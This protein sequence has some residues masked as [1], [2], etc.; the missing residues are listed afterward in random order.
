MQLYMDNGYMNMNNIINSS[1]PFIIVINGRGTGKTFNSLWY[2]LENHI[3]F[4]YMRRTKTQIEEIS[5]P[6]RDPFSDINKK[7]GTH[8]IPKNITK[9]TVGIY[10]GELQDDIYVPSGE[11]LGYICALSTFSTMRGLVD[12]DIDLVIFDEFIPEWNERPIREE[13]YTFLNAIETIGRNRELEGKQPL[14]TV[15]LSNSNTIVNPILVGMQIVN[16]IKKMQKENKEILHLTNRGI[17][18]IYPNHSPISDKKQETSLYKMA[19]N[20]GYKNMALK[21]TFDEFSAMKI[22][23]MPLNEYRAVAQIGELC[24]YKHKSRDEIYVSSICTGCSKI[25]GVS[26]VEKERFNRD[27]KSLTRL[28]YQGRIIFESHE[29]ELLFVHYIQKHY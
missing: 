25:Y 22:K 15:C 23:S 27:F 6:G 4:I 8:F 10:N 26:D 19:L 12:T 1:Y 5:T 21:N 18:V 11:C 13:Y 24:I 29:C 7:K 2:A 20:S 17:L 28:Y 3:K 16:N 9:N 14:Q